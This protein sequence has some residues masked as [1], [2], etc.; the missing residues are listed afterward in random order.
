MRFLY[1]LHD[2]F[3]LSYTALNSIFQS[4]GISLATLEIPHL[5]YY[6]YCCYYHYYSDIPLCIWKN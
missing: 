6:Y 2:F 3:F 5:H 4:N 1:L